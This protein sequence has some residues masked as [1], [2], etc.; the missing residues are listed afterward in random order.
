MYFYNQLAIVF[1]SFNSCSAIIWFYS[2]DFFKGGGRECQLLAVLL[3]NFSVL[4]QEREAYTFTSFL[5]CMLSLTRKHDRVVVFY[6]RD[7]GSKWAY[8]VVL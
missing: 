8:Q 2:D 1:I 5:R 3:L 6:C 7:D 4:G